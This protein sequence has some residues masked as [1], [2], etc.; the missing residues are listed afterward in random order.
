MPNTDIDSRQE[1]IGEFLV[2][3]G[4]MQAWQVDDILLVQRSGDPS[5]FRELAIALG[6]IDDWALRQYVESHNRK[7]QVAR[8]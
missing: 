5:M 6:Y 7:T 3:I 1:K 2:K 4:V 8:S